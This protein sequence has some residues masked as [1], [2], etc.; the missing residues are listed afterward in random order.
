MTIQR[1]LLLGRIAIVLALLG[2][3]TSAAQAGNDPS[4]KGDLRT[5]VHQAMNDF[6]AKNISGVLE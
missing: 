5:N 6:V 4:I 1:T 3:M 2:F